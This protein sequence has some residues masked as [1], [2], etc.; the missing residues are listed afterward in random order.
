MIMYFM[1]VPSDGTRRVLP[2]WSEAGPGSGQLT[3][4]KIVADRGSRRARAGGRGFEAGAEP[5]EIARDAAADLPRDQG[6]GPADEAA[7][8]PAAWMAIRVPEGPSDSDLRELFR[9][10]EAALRDVARPP[11]S[12]I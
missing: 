5:L 4:D 2:P 3:A 7:G 1:V 12:V 9:E 11:S 6:R 10:A 8:V